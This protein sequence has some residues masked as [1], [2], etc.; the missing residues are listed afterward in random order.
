MI[1]ANDDDLRRIYITTHNYKEESLN[2]ENNK[3]IFNEYIKYATLNS[4]RIIQLN[5]YPIQAQNDTK[6]SKHI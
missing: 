6:T 5:K 1:V 2:F 4:Y 3:K